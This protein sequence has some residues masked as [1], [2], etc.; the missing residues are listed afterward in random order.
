MVLVY[1]FSPLPLPNFGQK[2]N[3]KLG[4]GSLILI[5]CLSYSISSYSH[6]VLK[7]EKRSTA[8]PN[9]LIEI[10]TWLEMTKIS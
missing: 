9:K 3:E 8:K 2:K 5:P 7:I 1:E 6:Y 4:G 10:I